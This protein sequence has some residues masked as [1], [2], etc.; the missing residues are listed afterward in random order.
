MS[1]RTRSCLPAAILALALS[2]CA[3][4]GPVDQVEGEDVAIIG[5]G[6]DS[7]QGR[8]LAQVHAELGAENWTKA[9]AAL[10]PLVV[11]AAL[12]EGQQAL[13]AGRPRDAFQPIEAALALDPNAGEL[14]F[15]RAQAALATAPGDS[16]PVFFYE[17]AAESFEAAFRLGLAKRQGKVGAQEISCLVGISRAKRMA[18]D[19]D[20]ALTLA[21]NAH[22]A[23]TQLEGSPPTLDTPISRVWAEAAFDVFVAARKRDDPAEAL[24]AETEDQLSITTADPD[25]RQWALVQLSNLHQ[26][27]GGSSAAIEPIER[28]LEFAPEDGN[29][30][31][32]LVGLLTDAGGQTAVLERYQRWQRDHPNS[33]LGWW[34]SAVTL[35]HLGLAQFEAGN[36][37]ENTFLEA[38]EFF[39]RY[40]ELAPEFLSTAQ[41]YQASCRS[42]QGFIRLN[43]GDLDAAE[44]AFLSMQEVFP[45]AIE[46]ELGERIPSGLAGLDFV[47]GKHAQSPEDLDAMSAAARVANY[48]HAYRPTSADYA[49]NAGFFNRD[50]AVLIEIQAQSAA[51][52]GAEE[53]SK[54]LFAEALLVMN[55]SW[56][57]YQMAAELAPQDVRM[58]NDAGLVMTYY[59]RQDVEVA[60][61]LLE[62]ARAEGDRTLGKLTHEQ[63]AERKWEDPI[64]AWGDAYQNL[65]ILYLTLLGDPAGSRPFFERALEIGPPRRAW[66]KTDMLPM[67][68]RLIAG[69]DLPPEQYS[70]MV[71]L[72][73]S[74]AR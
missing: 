43:S 72:H 73:Q 10:I 74:P 65:G 14:H 2:A 71:W 42:A 26:W 49:N 54:A 15:L 11:G 22:K 37:D 36:G 33:A 4:N 62:Q 56:E 63:R 27:R 5:S 47:I 59:L 24:F 31:T 57:A 68:D 8:Q 21:R 17:D 19:P 48:L 3:S 41:A 53:E 34:Y 40:G 66:L 60:L 52:Q 32:R 7:L 6:S 30:H 13:D 67:V 64:E 20:M 23:M 50:A 44:E 16:Q 12:K 9:R 39:E 45:G 61:N 25:H 46:V 55:D 69:E 51:K 35:F 29:L 18:L 38:Q 70:S 1:S 58:V 28:A